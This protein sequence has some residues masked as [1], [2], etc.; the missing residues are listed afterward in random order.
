MPFP[1]YDA[2]AH[3][4]DEQFFEDLDEV[5]RRAAEAGVS[6][7]VNVGTDEKT[8]AL[9]LEQAA[10]FPGVYATAGLHPHDAAGLS[11]GSGSD[12]RTELMARGYPFR[13]ARNPSRGRAEGILSGVVRYRRRPSGRLSRTDAGGT[14]VLH[15]ETRS[16]P[17][18]GKRPPMRTALGTACTLLAAA[19]F[20]SPARAQTAPEIFAE[21]PC[22]RAT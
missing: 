4:N 12:S 20:A 22:R 21:S 19:T 6:R 16:G 13:C 8:S 3:L 1:L 15:D 2:H 17:S 11:A 9:A 7:I 18:N 5:V 14:V 10:R